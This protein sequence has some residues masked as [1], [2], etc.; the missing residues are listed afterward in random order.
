MEFQQVPYWPRRQDHQTFRAADHAGFT[1][2]DC[3]HRSRSRREVTAPTYPGSAPRFPHV[4]QV[5]GL[6]PR[7]EG[8][9]WG[10]G[11]PAARPEPR[12][13]K[14]HPGKELNRLALFFRIPLPALTGSV[15]LFWVSVS[16]SE[17]HT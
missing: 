12:S 13:Q 17:E 11:E 16:R 8:E 10:E 3:C 1:R 5:H 15:L 6:P 7:P 4:A 2:S 9:G 14:S